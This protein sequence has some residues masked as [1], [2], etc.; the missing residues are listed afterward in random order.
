MSNFNRRSFIKG[1]GALAAGGAL[2]PDARTEQQAATLAPL[3]ETC[4]D[5]ATKLAA[6]DSDQPESPPIPAPAVLR[7]VLFGGCTATEY[8]ALEGCQVYQARAQGR[9]TYQDMAPS[10]E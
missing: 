2:T 10:R 7:V 4:A 6:G 8:L 3:P 9:A 5:V 1:M